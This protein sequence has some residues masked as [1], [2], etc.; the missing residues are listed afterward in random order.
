MIWNATLSNGHEAQSAFSTG[1]HQSEGKS[2]SVLL[3][4]MITEVCLF[5]MRKMHGTI[6]CSGGHAT[7]NNILFV[8]TLA[9]KRFLKS[10][11]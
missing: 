5:Y 9:N 7:S 6:H 11:A 8:M 10:S 2:V 1:C 3:G 4:V